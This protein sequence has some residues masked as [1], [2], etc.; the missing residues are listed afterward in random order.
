MVSQKKILVPLG[1]QNKDLKGLYHAL[2]LAE[3]MQAKVIILRIEPQDGEN[4]SEMESWIQNALL[5]LINSASQEGLAVSYHIARG[6]V[7]EEVLGIVKEEDID[8]VVFGGDEE[9]I[10]QS[11]LRIKS[12]MPVQIIQVREKDNVHHL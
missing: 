11:L 8:L 1:L 9:E 6:R 3:R 4:D 10:A 2:A 5:D 12:R 7:E